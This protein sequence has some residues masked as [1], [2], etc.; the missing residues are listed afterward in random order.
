MPIAPI[1]D[2]GEAI[3]TSLAGALALFLTG[4]PLPIEQMVGE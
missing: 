2:W 1:S 3:R 4:T